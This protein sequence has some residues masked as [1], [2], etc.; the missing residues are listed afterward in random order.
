MGEDEA[1]KEELAAV[2]EEVADPVLDAMVA[3]VAVEALV[4]TPKA[5]GESSTETQPQ[6]APMEMTVATEQ[7]KM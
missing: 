6:P 2:A 7:I 4:E 5:E 3:G 1:R